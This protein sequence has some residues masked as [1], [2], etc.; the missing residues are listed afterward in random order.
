MLNRRQLT[1]IIIN[2]IIIKMLV[3][4]PHNAIVLCGNASWISAIYCTLIA[5]GLFW[6]ISVIYTSHKSVIEIAENIGGIWLR[7]V[8]GF[9]VFVVMAAGF[10]PFISIFSEIIRLALLQQ[11]LFEIIVLLL[12]IA[13]VLG[14]Y[15]GIEA[16]GRVHGLFI[17]IIGAVF[18]IFILLLIPSFHIENILPVMG[19]G[20]YNLFVRNISF[21]SLFADLLMLNILIPYT[22]NIGEYRKSGIKGVFIGGAC[23]II[24]FAVYGLSY[25]YPCSEK[26]IIPI[27]QL[28]K[29]IRVSNFFSRLEAVFQFVWSI[30][31]LLYGSLYVAVLA[32]V[33]RSGFGLKKSKPLILPVA[34]V[35]VGA[36]LIPGSFSEIIIW[37]GIIN[38]WIYIPAFLIPIL[39]GIIGRIKK[40]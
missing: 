12:I 13:I 23:A 32:E 11:T 16:I 15:C 22:K 19:N 1:T 7:M 21:L 33:W 4:F 36:A 20:I 31:I 27:Y 24:I 3:T 35:L 2:A 39:L 29:L 28:E 10:F 14:A 26:F 34:T 30:L 25:A 37:E 18:V 40:I 8:V 38:K 5:A 9:V 17:P 6:L